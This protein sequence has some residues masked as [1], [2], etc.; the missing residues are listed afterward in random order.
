MHSGRSIELLG[1]FTGWIVVGDGLLAGTVVRDSEH[2]P[3][4]VR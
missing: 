1:Q 4:M 2:W 3:G